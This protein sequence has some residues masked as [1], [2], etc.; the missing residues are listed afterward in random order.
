MPGPFPAHPIFLG[1]KPWERGA[2][3]AS[4]LDAETLGSPAINWQAPLQ[5]KKKIEFRLN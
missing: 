4:W 2:K 5:G 3:I 1:K